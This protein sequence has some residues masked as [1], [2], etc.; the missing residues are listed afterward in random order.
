MKST[1]KFLIGSLILVGLQ[2]AWFGCVGLGGGGGGVVV[3]GDGPSWFGG[4]GWLDGGGRGSYGDRGGGRSSYVHP[5]GL[6]AA[7][8]AAAGLAERE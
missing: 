3:Y 2:F 7:P 4:G 5:S 6:V 8:E 1:H